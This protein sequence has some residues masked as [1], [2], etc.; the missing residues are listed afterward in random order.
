MPS[1]IEI[2]LRQKKEGK[3]ELKGVGVSL[4]GFLDTLTKSA[5]AALAAGATFKKAFDLSREGANIKQTTESFERLNQNI[6]MTPDLLDSM[7]SAAKGTITQMDLMSGFMT[8]TAG[9][10]DTMARAFADAAPGLVEIAKAAEKL[11]PNLG[12]TQFMFDSVTRGI[13]RQSPLILDN[14]GIVVQVDQAN[15]AYAATLGKTAKQLSGEERTMALLN[16]VMKQGNVLVRQVGGS[17]DAQSDAWN[18]LETN[19]DNITNNIKSWFA[20]RLEPTIK[21]LSG[22]YKGAIEEAALAVRENVGVNEKWGAVLANNLEQLDKTGSLQGRITGIHG[23]L[24]D[25]LGQTLIAMAANTGSI[26]EMKMA[27]VDG[28]EGLIRFRTNV[29][30][31]T[32]TVVLGNAGYE[33]YKITLDELWLITTKATQAQDRQNRVLFEAAF[34]AGLADIEARN[35]VESQVALAKSHEEAE[36]AGKKQF[37]GLEDLAVNA[38]SLATHFIGLTIAENELNIALGMTDEELEELAESEELAADKAKELADAT[39]AASKAFGAALTSIREGSDKADLF[40]RAID[41]IGEAVVR[42]GGRTDQQQEDMEALQGAYDS[43]ATRLHSYEIGLRGAGLS[44]DELNEK[45]QIERDEMARLSGFIGPLA[46][47]TG[48]LGTVNRQASWDTDALGLALVG[49]TEAAGADKEDWF[50]LVTTIGVLSEEQAIAVLKTQAMQAAII[51]LG[52]EI[53]KGLSI[54]EALEKLGELQARIDEEH[55]MLLETEDE[56]VLTTEENLLRTEE[57]LD[58]IDGR[59]ITIYVDEVTG[60]VNAGNGSSGNTTEAESTDNTGGPV[61]TEFGGGNF[62]IPKGYESGGGS[63]SRVI[64]NRTNINF[65]DGINVHA[66]PGDDVE[67]IA[68]KVA[69]KIANKTRQFSISGMGRLGRGR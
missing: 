8:V 1:L 4:N 10:S 18:R 41:N 16:A 63:G 60:F 38:G 25:E 9:V 52:E 61:L 48:T 27:L 21:I 66:Q 20:G 23:Q 50:E 40:T 54:P 5:A 34:K 19:I 30:T 43:A 58:R 7:T 42:F 15:R 64:S 14:L 57:V 35:L 3:D 55:E 51:E 67:A 46:S 69:E 2:I 37:D 28:S 65:H 36:E 11:N 12:N 44:T 47:I 49:A 32:Q 62:V 24:R 56:E 68:E 33:K 26:E 45:M 13:K 29:R 17:V 31:G 22:D 53:A 6:L 59:R 39:L